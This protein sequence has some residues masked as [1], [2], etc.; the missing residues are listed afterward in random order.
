MILT[1]VSVLFVIL[2]GSGECQ[3]C[4]ELF[5][6]NGDCLTRDRVCNSVN[7][8]TDGRGSYIDEANCSGK[9]YLHMF[10]FPK[11]FLK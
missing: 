11:M 10:V 5:C 4:S 7:D 3:Q 9:V 8:C 1:A 6:P 2:I